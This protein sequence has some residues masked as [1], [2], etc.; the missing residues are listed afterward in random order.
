MKIKR[1]IHIVLL[2]SLFSTIA[3]MSQQASAQSLC[4]DGKGY[5]NTP[6]PANNVS[7]NM[8]G[9][10][11][12]QFEDDG[13]RYSKNHPGTDYALGCGSQIPGPPPG[14]ALS[15]STAISADTQSGRGNQLFFDC[16]VNDAGQSIKLHY[17]H[18]QNANFNPTENLITTGNT[19]S[20]G[21]HLDFI[22]SVDGQTI[23]AQCSTGTVNTSVY[24]YG[25]SSTRHGATCPVSGQP[26]LCDSEVVNQLLD[27]GRRAREGTTNAPGVPDGP[28]GGAAPAPPD[29]P[30]VA[31]PPGT[32]GFTGYDYETIPNYGQGGQTGTYNRDVPPI[33][34]PYVPPPHRNL[35]DT[36]TCITQDTVSIADHDFVRFDNVETDLDLITSEGTCLPPIETGVIVQRQIIGG[37][38]N[39]PD[40]F[41]LNKGCSYIEEEGCL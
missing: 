28:G 38:I 24:Q 18:L 20:G 8:G 33:R 36:P 3:I 5:I 6:D 31:P 22:M 12:Q 32:P 2:S 35:C 29:G 34:T 30:T 11:I 10:Y 1:V 27:Q 40:S 37:L 17:S 39:Y 4:E 13:T 23:D 9:R 7:S 16:G 15:G 25:K 19:G 26:N 21:C 41:C 14:C